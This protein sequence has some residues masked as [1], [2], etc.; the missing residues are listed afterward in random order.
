MATLKTIT[1]NTTVSNPSA[2][3]Y[4]VTGAGATLTNP[5]NLNVA[6]GAAVV[7]LKANNAVLINSGVIQGSTFAEV[8]NAFGYT[9]TSVTNTSTGT[10]LATGTAYAIEGFGLFIVTNAGQISSGT[11]ADILFTQGGTLLNSGTITKT[12]TASGV[13]VQFNVAAGFLSNTSAGIISGNGVYFKSNSSNGTVINA[14]KILGATYGG[15]DMYAG[16]RVT[17]LFGGT[18]T[19]GTSTYGVKIKGGAGTVTN[20]GTILNSGGTTANAVSLASGFANRVILETGAYFRGVVQGGSAATLE[21]GASYAATGTLT[22]FG[23]QFTNFS[24]ITIDSGASWAWASSDSLTG[25]TLTDSGT[26]VNGVTLSAGTGRINLAAG[27]VLSNLATGTVSSSFYETAGA[28]VVNAG[29]IVNNVVLQSGFTNRVAIAPGAIFSGTVNGGNASTATGISVLE[30]ESTASTGTLSSFSTKYSN[31]SQVTIDSGANW[32]LNNTDVFAAG[33]TLNNAGTIA[34]ASNVSFGGPLTNTGAINLNSGSLQIAALSGAGTLNFGA[35]TGDILALSSA[36]STVETINNMQSGQTIEI[37]GQSITSAN[38]LAGNTLALGF[39]G[40]TLN[41]KLDPT[42]NF[43]GKFFHSAV[44]TN[45]FIT[46][47]TSPCYLAGTRIRT[48]RGEIPVEDLTIGDCVVTL[49]GT[50]KPI[51]WIGRRAYSSAFAAGNRDVIPILIKTG[52]LAENVPVRDLYVSP[53]HAMFLDNVLVPAEHLVNGASIVR[54][55]EIDPIRYFHIELDQHDVVFADGA[56]AETFI[57]CDS[58]GIFHNAPEF[59]ELYPDEHPQQWK[60]CAPRI[61]SGPVLEQIRQAINSRAGLTDAE[62]GPL[63]GNLDG[64]DGTTIGGWAFDPAHPD[65][66]VNLEILDGDG[67][68]ARVTANRFRADLE[69][70]GIRDGRHGFELR[71]SRPLSS[72]TRHEIR[73]RRLADGRELPGCPLTIESYDRATSIEQARDA[74]DLAVETAREAGAL[75]GLLDTLLQGIERVRRLRATQ[76]TEPGD[77]RLLGPA[78]S[79]RQRPKCALIVDT[80]LPRAGSDPL[81]AEMAALRAQGWVVEFVASA[82]LARGDEAVAALEAFGVTCHRAPLIASV[83]EVLR[84]KRDMFDLVYLRGEPNAE[85]YA[86]LARAWQPR[87]R[88][89]FGID[90]ELLADRRAA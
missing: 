45:S 81:F 31:F 60:F 51:K 84:R 53:L 55:P 24:Q 34:I 88:L 89:V 32:S 73:V 25:V 7:S 30:L 57:D 86:A 74:I 68:I 56:T 61:E 72:H 83:E 37:L 9:N 8:V 15:V 1:S 38:L 62:P 64:L 49:D 3:Y 12:G 71:L 65:T 29:K 47:D 16:G 13:A 69:A 42:Q 48:D 5:I 54:C 4:A 58:R 27:G 35:A 77:D 40:G 10:I 50:A 6:T 87:A 11:A 2:F 17:N 14:G 75:D 22:N 36:A 59:S 39:S 21:L 43:T 63:Q 78:K 85:A 23:S 79:H 33:I 44:G 52:A 67:L 70:A 18:I 41:V 76:Q 66:P 28:T 80:L 46:E 90:G 26:L 82:G 20:A 19:A